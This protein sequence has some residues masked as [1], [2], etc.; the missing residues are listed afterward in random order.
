MNLFRFLARVAFALFT[1][2]VSE[3][4]IWKLSHSDARKGSTS[5]GSQWVDKE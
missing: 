3:I 1:V 5:M 2:G 4:V